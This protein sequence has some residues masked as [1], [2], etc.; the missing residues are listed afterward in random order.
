MAYMYTENKTDAPDTGKSVD[1]TKNEDYLFHIYTLGRFEIYSN[2]VKI[3]ESSKRS[4]RVWNL[5]KYIMSNRKKML[6]SGELIDVIWGE[7][8][9]ENPEKAL[10]NLIYRLR[11]FLSVTVKADDLIISNQGCYKWNEKFPVWIDCDALVEYSE[12]GKEL[13]NTAPY[14]AKQCFEKVIELYNGEF[15]SDIVYDIWVLPLR[16]MYKKKYVDCVSS[17][18]EILDMS[19]DYE[20]VVRVCD[21]FFNHEF[22]DEKNN[23][24]FLRALLSL[25]RRQEAQKHYDTMADSMYRELG[26]TPSYRFAD[27]LKEV[28]E[29]PAKHEIKSAKN[30]NLELVN[31][32]LWQDERTSGAYQCDKDTFMAISKVMLRNLERS[33]LSIMMVLATFADVETS[34]PEPPPKPVNAVASFSVF[35]GGAKKPPEQQ[36]AR[37]K[38]KTAQSDADMSDTIEEARKKFV[39][40]FRRGDIVCLWNPTQILIMLTNLTFEDAETAMERINKKIQAEI[41]RDKYTLDYKIIPLEHEII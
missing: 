32:M 10:Q 27:I 41:L 2:G 37:V 23:R 40:A 12:R 38:E 35:G 14:D 30:I 6:S 29:N 39:Y 4:I 26:V 15:L 8:S 11:Q 28:R 16:T 3:T 13:L 36:P 18:L 34:A 22:F 21:N 17:Y 33:G 24:Y 7:D 19:G 25:D 20:T 9:C 5:F 31:D 1:F